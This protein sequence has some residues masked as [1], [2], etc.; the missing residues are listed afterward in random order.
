MTAIVRKDEICETRELSLDEL[1]Q[2]AGGSVGEAIG[3]TVTLV[4][5]VLTGKVAVGHC[6]GPCTVIAY[7]TPR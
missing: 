5:G 4:L 1:D 2:V 7:T 3:T 6:D